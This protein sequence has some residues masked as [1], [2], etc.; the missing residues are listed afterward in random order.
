MFSGNTD[1]KVFEF[2]QTDSHEINLCLQVN[3]IYPGLITYTPES[4]YQLAYTIPKPE[5]KCPCTGACVLQ[6]LT[7]KP[8]IITISNIPTSHGDFIGHSDGQVQR[9]YYK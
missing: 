2:T 4:P 8:N 6:S 3:V 1:T 5:K 7:L 9:P